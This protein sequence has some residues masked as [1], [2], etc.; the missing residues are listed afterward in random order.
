MARLD[1]PFNDYVVTEGGRVYRTYHGSRKIRELKTH[2][3]DGTLRELELTGVR[4]QKMHTNIAELVLIAYRGPRPRPD[5]SPFFH[6]SDPDNCRLSNLAW[7]PRGDRIR[8]T[9]RRNGTLPGKL[10]PRD[11]RLIRLDYGSGENTTLAEVA[12]TWGISVSTVSRIVNH[13]IHTDIV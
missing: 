8:Q 13:E 9:M 7:Q 10:S 6:D 2:H 11:I 5:Y 3:S 4:G 12:E 1:H